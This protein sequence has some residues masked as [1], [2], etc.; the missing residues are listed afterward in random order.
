MGSVQ[1]T[2]P[3]RFLLKTAHFI[4]VLTVMID[5]DTVTTNMTQIDPKK[6]IGDDLDEFDKVKGM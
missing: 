6:A 4:A 3:A 2:L 5:L 1:I